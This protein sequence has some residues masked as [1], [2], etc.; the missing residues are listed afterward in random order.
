[1]LEHLHAQGRRVGVISHVEELKERI[2]V[3]VEITPGAS[4]RST[5]SIM[6]D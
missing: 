2:P 4:G 5:L 1:M 3:K 6:T